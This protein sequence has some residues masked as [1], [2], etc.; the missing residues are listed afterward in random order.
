L[1]VTPGEVKDAAERYLVNAVRNNLTSQ[2]VLGE[3]NDTI[4]KSPEWEK[5][6]FDMSVGEEQTQASL[7]ASAAEADESPRVTE[8]VG[9]GTP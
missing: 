5:F 7:E 1:D 6:N 2:A 8:A 3:I 9:G 4:L